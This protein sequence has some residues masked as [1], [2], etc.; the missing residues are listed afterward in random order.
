MIQRRSRTT[1]YVRSS[2]GSS[3]V[4]VPAGRPSGMRAPARS[5]YR[6]KRVPT[7][8]QYSRRTFRKNNQIANTLSMF[9]EKKYRQFLSQDEVAPSAIQ[10][11]AQ[12]YYV[13]FVGGVS[14]PS[15]WTGFTPI[16]GFQYA[17]GTGDTGRD[18]RYMFLDNSTI[19]CSVHMNSQIRNTP[20][21]QFR[22]IV[23]KARR[24][25]TPTGVSYDPARTLFLAP[26]GNSI[27]HGV[28]GVL[29]TDLMLQPTN[30]RDW[31][32]LKDSK[33]VL[34][35]PMGA[36]EETSSFQGKYASFKQMRINLTHKAKSIFENVN[37]QPVDFDFHYG[38]V[39]YSNAI[40]RDNSSNQWEFNLRGTTTA[41][42]N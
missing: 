27:G 23:F 15:T 35:A 39:I 33:F 22:C 38:I 41:F 14:S 42:D 37:D 26:N 25:T 31:I 20:P 19:N 32:I 2:A 40:G 18:G 10:L 34:Q 7:R 8:L 5:S 13:G 29:G 28:G 6:R 1:K 9:S 17:Q 16:Q 36:S 4:L 24:A 21:V 30:K 11:G 3:G 12:S